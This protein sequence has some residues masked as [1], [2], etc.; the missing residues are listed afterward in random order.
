MGAG[1]EG[2]V[3]PYLCVR[4]GVLKY[5]VHNRINFVKIITVELPNNGHIGSR[6]FVL[7]MEVVPLQKRRQFT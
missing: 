7:Y 1:K 4:K 5:M 2:Q 3:Q 6:P